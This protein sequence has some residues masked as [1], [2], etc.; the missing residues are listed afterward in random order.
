MT[1]YT[2]RTYIHAYARTY[3]YIYTDTQTNTHAHTFIQIGRFCLPI[4][5]EIRATK[6]PL[7]RRRH[8]TYSETVT[9]LIITSGTNVKCTSS[10]IK[11]NDSTPWLTNITTTR[12]FFIKPTSE[13]ESASRRLHC[14]G[15]RGQVE[16]RC[17][18]SHSRKVSLGYH[19]ISSALLYLH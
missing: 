17:H 4:T 5:G 15:P 2:L 9:Q 13:R 18:T 10:A 6:A 11:G 19:S 16:L 8:N 14:G 12:N 3:I 1:T 7:A